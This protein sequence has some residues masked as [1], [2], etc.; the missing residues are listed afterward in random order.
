MKALTRSAA[1][2]ALCAALPALAQDTPLY[3]DRTRPVDER[4]RDLLARMTLEEKVAQTLGIWKGKEKITDAAG[5]FDP[6]GARAL[7]A[8][9]L[10]QLARPTEL[11][12]KPTKILNGPREN[13]VFVNAVQ[14]WLIENTRLGIPV[15]THEE[16]LHGLVAPKGTN[17]PIPIALAST[18]DPALVERVMSIA[19][20]EARARGTHE[21]LSPVLDLARDPRWG[22]TEETYGE[23]PYL[24]SRLGVAAIRGYQGT[25]RTLAKDKVLATA[26]HFAGHGPHEGGINT[27][28]TA[29]AERLLRDQYLFP[30]EA[31]IAE[32]PVM[33]VM[34]SYNEMDGVPSHKNR[35]LLGR[36]LRQEWGFD[37]MVVSDYYAVDQM[38]SQHG[39]AADL[40]D[41]A[42]Q[43]IEA[44]V[45]IELPDMAAYPKLADVV[46]SG[47]LSEAVL[48]RAVAR[49][50]RAKF[51]AGLFDDPYVD[52]DRAEKV[53]NT[54]E[55]QAVA[56]EAARRAIVLLKNDGSL[57]PLDPKRLK[58]IAVIGP[59]AKG[60]RLGG[61]SSVPGRGVDI[62][63]GIT[64]KAGAGVRVLYAE[65]TRIT[66]LPAN[67]TED[68][69]V[70]GDPVKN[71]QRIAEAVTV[72]R[73]ADVAVVVIGTNESTSREAWADNHLGDVADLELSSQQNDLVDAVRG[74][75]KP[76]VVVLINGRPLALSH[77]AATVPAILEGF[78][79]GQEG[80][81]AV[82]EVLFGD[83]NPGG[84][85]P[86]TFP[87]ATGQL[88]VYYDRKPTSF[89]S[90]LDLTREPLF[91]F[92]HGLSY[93][94]FKLDNVKV[95]PDKIGTG[96]EAT[97]TVDVTNTGAR[98]GDEVVQLYVRDRV[99]SVTRPVKELRGFER[100]TLAPGASQTVT[101]K[102]GPAA[103]RFTDEQ[104]NRVV[105][106]GLFDL[107]VGT[108]SKTTATT[109]LEVV[110]RRTP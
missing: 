52:P 18:W 26:K 101:F 49:I 95:T 94:T 35:W 53:S 10:G 66:E 36:V 107:M 102:V 110:D 63:D 20:L 86:I 16:A 96:G 29:F 85:L 38:V 25:S 109:S 58:T 3:R 32:T 76:V 73:Q 44:G 50:L 39:V 59:N 11:R 88:P 60:V 61:Y 2:L 21:V 12:D 56:L 15:M 47:R 41:A 108:S 9:G 40:A 6:A 14:K 23:D 43:A 99:A 48:D 74:T 105:E 80:G 1:V 83:V 30:F 106:P 89:R 75:G 51:L 77:L 64:Q 22:R 91:P 103:L 87:R 17:F 28:P 46:K 45:D 42:R 70:F 65:G 24:V 68:K 98:A 37:G 31:A 27:A 33:A 92:G 82:A 55:H 19:A 100:V 4:V 104:M 93:T 84:K 8:N 67:W 71:R 7:I 34:P 57:L 5:Q 69:V 54:P 79:L 90:Y 78:Y 62:L 13:A 97:V 81:T 72:A